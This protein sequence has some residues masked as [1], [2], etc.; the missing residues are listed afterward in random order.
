MELQI[1]SISYMIKTR[2]KLIVIDVKITQVP[3]VFHK[4]D[5]A[6]LNILHC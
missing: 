4:S 6:D 5:N 3:E 2:Y 1:V